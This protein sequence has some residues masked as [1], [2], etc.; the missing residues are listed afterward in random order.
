MNQPNFQNSRAGES[1]SDE[2]RNQDHAIRIALLEQSMTGIKQELHQINGNI[3][4]LVWAVIAAIVMAGVQFMLRG[5]L[6][7]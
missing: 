6:S 1:P 5:G 3:S 7:A 4:R 2:R